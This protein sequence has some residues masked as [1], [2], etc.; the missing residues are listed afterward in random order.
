MFVIYCLSQLQM[1][2]YLAI[3]ENFRTFLNILYKREQPRKKPYINCTDM[4]VYI[5]IYSV[6]NLG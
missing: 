3:T 2:N 5:S 6:Y 1:P 4:N